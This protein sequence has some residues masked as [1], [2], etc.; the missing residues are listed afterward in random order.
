MPGPHSS[1]WPSPVVFYDGD[2][3]LCHGAVR[4]VL[5]RDRAAIFRFAPLGS[6]AFERMI[7]A[8]ERSRIPDSMVV[9]T[10]DQRTLTQ[11]DAVVEML[12]QLGGVWGALSLVLGTLPRAIRNP[13][14]RFVAAV[15]ASLFARPTD[16]CPVMAPDLRG[17]FLF[18]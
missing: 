8:E 1:E 2:C 11:S 18:D 7:P 9:R 17:R 10:T 14:Y 4:F 15:R 5:A 16:A 6:P 12:R 3:G 13:G